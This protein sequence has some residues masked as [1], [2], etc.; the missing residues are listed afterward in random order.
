MC[1]DN[2]KCL[3]V[4]VEKCCPS[5]AMRCVGLRG[6]V[7][8]GDRMVGD[9]RSRMHDRV[10]HDRRRDDQTAGSG[11]GEGDG[12]NARDDDLYASMEIVDGLG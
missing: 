1:L 5:D 6:R 3:V 12:Q 8:D 7:A 9:Q 11:S 10:V 2:D 4:V